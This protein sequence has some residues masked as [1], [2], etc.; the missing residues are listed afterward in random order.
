MRGSGTTAP[1]GQ[2][3]IEAKLFL[4]QELQI[5]LLYLK[6]QLIQALDLTATIIGGREKILEGDL[7]RERIQVGEVKLYSVEQE[8]VAITKHRVASSMLI[9][10]NAIDV[11][12]R[13]FRD[14]RFCNMSSFE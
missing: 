11:R 14:I 10:V 9:V 3:V 13:P 2:Q 8:V 7:D 4:P 1:W 12:N 5:S 6:L